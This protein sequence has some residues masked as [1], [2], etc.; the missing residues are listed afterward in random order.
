MSDL[1]LNNRT[2]VSSAMPCSGTIDI[3]LTG[4]S[5]NA[6]GLEIILNR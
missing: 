4:G 6:I 5:T 1:V 3:F 2:Q